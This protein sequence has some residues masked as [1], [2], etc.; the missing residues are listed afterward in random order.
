M[1]KRVKV[2]VDLYKLKSERMKKSL[3]EAIEMIKEGRIVP[4]SKKPPVEW[5][6]RMNTFW[7]SKM[8]E[9]IAIGDM[10]NFSRAKQEIE[11]LDNFYGEPPIKP[12]AGTET[13]D[14]CK[15]DL[16]EIYGDEVMPY[17]EK[18]K[19]KSG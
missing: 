7:K 4:M 12:K 2:P 15:I 9:A 14:V 19:E 16:V 6:I 17:I 11:A 8:E 13:R 1:M 3:I 10:Q 18:G 5:L